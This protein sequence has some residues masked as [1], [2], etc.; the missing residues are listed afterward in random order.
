MVSTTVRPLSDQKVRLAYLP[1]EQKP[2]LI[3][4]LHTEENFDWNKPFDRN[5]TSVTAMAYINRF[6]EIFDACGIRPVYLV[7]YPVAVQETGAAPLR[8]FISSNR[9]EI[10]AHLHPWV[11]PPFEEEVN[12]YNS[13]AGNLP[14][15]I[16]QAKIRELVS[17]IENNIGVR[18]RSYLAGRYG[19]GPNTANILKEE[20]FNVDISSSPAFDLRTDGGYDYSRYPTG[21]YWLD[22]GNRLLEVPTTGAFIGSLR[23]FGPALFPLIKCKQLRWLR[24]GGI[25]S[26]LKVLQRLRLSPEGFTYADMRRLTD[27]LLR[28]GERIFI[29]SLHS[30]CVMPGC[31][32]WVRTETDLKELL[33]RCLRYFRYFFNELD[34][35]TMTISELYKH[36]SSHAKERS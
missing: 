34:G 33:E 14:R 13:F 20:G 15:E 9:A 12:A 29:F 36:V 2:V 11:C 25:L 26:R 7:G 32:P 21:P 31:T 18:A 6:Q 4:T 3:V 8:S 22:Q 35:I 5:E 28:N 30:T 19:F 16:E 17:A 23:N 10:G 24:I 27:S 1:R